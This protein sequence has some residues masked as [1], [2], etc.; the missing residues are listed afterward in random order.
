MTYVYAL[1][2]FFHIISENS[3]DRLSKMLSEN[4]Y[5][6]GH[7]TVV[8]GKILQKMLRKNVFFCPGAEAPLKLYKT[9]LKLYK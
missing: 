2:S 4:I 8:N 1:V 9:L 3:K 5:S 6:H 7:D